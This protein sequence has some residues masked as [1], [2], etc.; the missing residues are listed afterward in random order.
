AESLL[1]SEIRDP[2]ISQKI[3]RLLGEIHQLDMP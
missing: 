3:G 1:V 2:K